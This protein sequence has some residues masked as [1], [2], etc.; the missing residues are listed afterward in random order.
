[1]KEEA[2]GILSIDP[3]DPRF[4]VI[5]WFDYFEL[6]QMKKS[7]LVRLFLRLRLIS[8]ILNRNKILKIKTNSE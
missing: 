1:M 6:M 4:K 5:D 8:A 3:D 2:Q 7:R